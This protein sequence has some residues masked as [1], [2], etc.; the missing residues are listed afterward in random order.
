MA[1]KDDR[2]ELQRRFSGLTSQ[3]RRAVVKAV[4]RGRAVETRKHAPLAVHVANRQ[5]RFWKWSWVIGPAVGL[6]QIGQLGPA[7]A[8]LNALLATAL[9]GSM[10]AFFYLRAQRSARANLEL[11]GGKRPG[12]GFDSPGPRRF[13]G[14]GDRGEAKSKGGTGGGDAATDRAQGSKRRWWGGRDTRPTTS[15]PSGSAG[16]LPSRPG[17]PRDTTAQG[18][19]DT[20]GT[21]PPQRSQ[22]GLPP[23]R[24]PYQPRG[25]KRRGR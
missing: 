9:L 7:A 6:L 18:D 19:S 10:S 14:R 2:Q 4:N 21:T 8:V 15:S 11:M 13:G 20:P 22:P 24:R 16:H 1:S 25:K 3:Q 23:D 12:P 5:M 17:R